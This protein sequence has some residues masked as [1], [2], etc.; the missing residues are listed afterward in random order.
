MAGRMRMKRARRT[1][2]R[3]YRRRRMFKKVRKFTKADGYHLEKLTYTQNLVVTGGAANF[4]IFWNKP[5]DLA[6]AFGKFQA[7]AGTNNTN[8]QFA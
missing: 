5:M 7:F 1:S 8:L 4:H 6:G 2:R 3:S